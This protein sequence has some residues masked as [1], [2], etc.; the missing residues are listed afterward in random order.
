MADAR[1]LPRGRHGLTREQVEASLRT[2]AQGLQKTAG[3]AADPAA[4]LDSVMRPCL[5]ALE[6]SGL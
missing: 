5:S 4:Y 3:E 1:R 2:E 6:T